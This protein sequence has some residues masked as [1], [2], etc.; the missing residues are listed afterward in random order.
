MNKT[1]LTLALLAAAAAG[2]FAVLTARDL[3]R[4]EQDVLSRWTELHRAEQAQFAEMPAVLALADAQPALDAAVRTNAR[5]RCSLLAQFDSGG[6]VIDDARRFDLYKQVRAECTGGLFRLL[7]ALRDAP[8]LAADSH[9]QALG[10]SLTQGQAT[11]DS[12][13]ERYR[14]ALAT[15]NEGIQHLPRGLAARLLGYEERP[16]FVRY[17]DAGR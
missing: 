7:A 14:Q 3:D 1:L 10:R 16:D 17:A 6:A 15:Y 5:S 2:G 11:V 13:R 9:V 8:P 12:A 4:R